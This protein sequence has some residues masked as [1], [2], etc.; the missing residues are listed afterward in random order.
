MSHN[1]EH[2]EQPKQEN[3][4]EIIDDEYIRPEDIAEE[5][6]IDLDQGEPMED[7]SDDD[8]GE[9]ITGLE[10]YPMR[11]SADDENMMELADDSVQGFFD[12]HEPVYGV[13]LHPKDST[14]VISGGGDDKSYLW[15]NDTGEKI[16]QLDGH[17]DSVTAVAFSVDGDY[18]ASAG[19]DGKVR[20][21]K[22]HTGEFC[23]AV[24]GP[25]EI[26]WIDWHPKG[27]IVLAG[28]SDSTIWMWAMPSG[29]FMNIFNGHIG[30]VTAGHF[31]TDGKKIVSVAE[32]TSLIIWD[33]KSAAA[34]HR[35]SGEDAR[36][37][38]E[39]ITSIA[40]NKESTLAITGCMDGKAR[41]IN[42]TNGQIVASLENHTGSIE[43]ADFCDILSLAATGSTDGNIS[44][45][46]VQTQRLR[47]TLSHEDAVVKVKFVKNSPLLVSCSADKSIKMWDV[48]TGQLI[49]SWIGHSD[50]VLDFAVSD[51]GK[52]IVSG[53]DD[54]TCLVFKA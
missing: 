50:T 15:R 52:T 23:T 30:P 44:I 10:G 3:N 47:S 25:D 4:D 32:D 37:H 19:M 29:K 28:A 9:P 11:P 38:T 40:T 42:I 12:H 1:N 39:P 7:E 53:S 18:V 14:I 31:T 51:D 27:N 43:T 54:G 13:A 2:S 8:Q 21:W 6:I 22:A 16:F 41:L 24:E 48:R 26:V 35:L 17:T 45:W 33:P 34:L 20:V 5:T 36:F 46:D 49:K